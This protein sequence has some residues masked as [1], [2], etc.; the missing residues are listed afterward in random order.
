MKAWNEICAQSK[1]TL[2]DQNFGRHYVQLQIL[3]THPQYH[4]LGAGTALCNWGL[5][6]S[7]LE[8]VVVAV[9]ASPMGRKLYSCLGFQP[10][11]N[12]VIQAPGE[13]EHISIQAMIYQPEP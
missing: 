13:E 3:A 1:Y 9:F 8:K 7:R 2:F 10:I 11:S 12:V 4:R 6:M 5:K